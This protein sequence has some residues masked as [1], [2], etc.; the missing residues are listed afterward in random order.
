MKNVLVTGGK[1]Q[2]AAAIKECSKNMRE[3]QFFFLDS[4]KL[5]I[6]N[7][8]EV[9]AFFQENKITYCINCAAY[10]NV[11]QAE[12]EKEIAQ[13]INEEGAKILA[14]ACS[15]YKSE[16]IQISTDY[17]F[18]GNQ[19]KL[20]TENDPPNPLS[21][22]GQTKLDGE[23][24]V[25]S[26][27]AEHYIIRTSWL[28]SEYGSNFL[29]T[30]LKLS[31]VKNEISV[32]CDQIGTP[33]NATDLATVVLKIINENRKAYGTYHF[34]N[35]G[36]ASWYDFAKAIF[37]ESNSNTEVVPI[38][39]EEFPTLAERPAFSILDKSKIKNEFNIQIPYWRDSLIRSI[40]AINEGK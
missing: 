39:S 40:K 8:E 16:L 33:T 34:S 23:I 3:Y 5:D 11:D 28:Y 15:R 7:T 12:N 38:K 19:A 37:K 9:E 26:V 6:T 2:L 24:A 36:V 25:A 21:M 4:D 31:K 29:K 27:L 1:G 13:T 22:Y 20:Y 32:V 14:Q 30:M 18:D 17:V 35:E 10:T